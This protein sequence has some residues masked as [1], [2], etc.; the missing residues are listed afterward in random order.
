M[1]KDFFGVLG[2][3]NQFAS[4]R[5][6]SSAHN[7]CPVVGSTEYFFCRTHRMPLIC[8]ENHCGPDAKFFE[9]KPTKHW[10]EFWK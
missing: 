4:C 5:H 2:I 1:R 9:P 3:S 8:L 6:P 10:W 7:G